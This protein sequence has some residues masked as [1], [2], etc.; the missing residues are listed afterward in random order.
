MA[1][2]LSIA[3]TEAEIT[4]I[5]Q[6]V[7]QLATQMPFLATV[8]ATDKKRRQKMGNNAASYVNK[9]LT[10][11]RNY[12]Q[13]LTRS[14]EVSEYE[15]DAVAIRQLTDVRNKVA[16]LLSKMED[17]ITLLGEEL[18]E[19]SNEVYASLQRAAQKDNSLR[20]VTEEMGQFYRKRNQSDESVVTTAK[21]A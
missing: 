9:G 8:P 16:G 17:T 19:Q 1:N 18:M 10:N 2:Q 21:V 5:L 15:K 11:A 13:V 6:T 14:F 12:P 7:D 4:A 3:L 20:L